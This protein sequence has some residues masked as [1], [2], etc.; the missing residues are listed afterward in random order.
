M[1]IICDIFTVMEY[2]KYLIKKI[3]ISSISFLSILYLLFDIL[4]CFLEGERKKEI[5]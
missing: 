2:S 5:E 1:P 4:V 3:R